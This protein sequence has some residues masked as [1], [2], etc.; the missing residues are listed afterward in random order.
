MKGI[1][2]LLMEDHTRG[3]G[4]LIKC[5]VKDISYGQ[6]GGNIKVRLMSDNRKL[7]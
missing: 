1:F 4:C 6:M 7:Y 3:N 2:D 5:M